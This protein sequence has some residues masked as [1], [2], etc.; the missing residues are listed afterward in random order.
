MSDTK[1]KKLFNKVSCFLCGQKVF[2]KLHD[3]TVEPLMLN[4]LF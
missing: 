3:I 4:G 1:E 2:S